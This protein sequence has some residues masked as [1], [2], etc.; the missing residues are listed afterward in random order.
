ML[1]CFFAYVNNL[2]KAFIFCGGF[3][4][5]V[6]SILVLRRISNVPQLYKILRSECDRRC[7][8]VLCELTNSALS[9]LCSESNVTLIQNQ[10]SYTP[11]FQLDV[12]DA[13]PGSAR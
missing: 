11:A 4:E 8:P 2:Q 1:P 3:V 6:L 5:N 9:N 7:V 12:A 10:L 13:S